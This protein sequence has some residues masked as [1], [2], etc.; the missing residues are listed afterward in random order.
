MLFLAIFLVFIG[1]LTF[2][3]KSS[4]R[5]QRKSTQ[6]FLDLEAQ[7][8]AT[9]KK[10]LDSI[11][12]LTIPLERLP[13]DAST[14]E[15]LLEYQNSIRALSNEKIADFSGLSNTELK[16]KYGASNLDQVAS[17]DQNYMQLLRLLYQWGSELYQKGLLSE[18]KSV[19]EYGVACKTDISKHYTL[20]AEIYKTENC[21]RKIS[22]L[23]TVAESLTCLMKPQII[24]NLKTAL[25]ACHDPE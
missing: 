25:E 18:S 17:Y 8:N 11:Q 14:D 10:P 13:M 16:L 15:T 20:L 3:I 22:S 4:D 2:K 5:R 7:A 24:Q 9:R 12:F 6:Q 1:L 19:L 21:P 23:I